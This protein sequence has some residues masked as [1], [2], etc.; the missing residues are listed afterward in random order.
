MT[1]PPEAL[2]GISRQEIP[3]LLVLPGVSVN[4]IDRRTHPPLRE[5]SRWKRPA[6]ELASGGTT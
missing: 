5:A 2:V 3:S 1:R 6:R 4:E